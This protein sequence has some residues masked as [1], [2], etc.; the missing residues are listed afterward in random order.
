MKL[1]ITCTAIV[2]L[3]L[4]VAAPPALAVRALPTYVPVPFDSPQPQAAAQFGTVMA[5]VGDVD[6]DGIADVGVSATGQNVGGLLRAGTVWVFS[7]ATRQVIRTI[8]SPDPQSGGG[9]GDSI[10]GIGDVSGDG[11]A[12]FMI[13]QD[14]LDVFVGVDANGVANAQ[15][16]G[17]VEPN[18]C[19]EG[20]GRLYTFSGATGALIRRIDDPTPQT[21]AFFGA[22]TIAPGDLNGNGSIDIVAG[23]FETV[24]TCT[25]DFDFDPTT[26][27]T[28][29]PCPVGAADAVDSRTGALIHR[30]DDPDPA[31][32]VG[33]ASGI[34]APG[35][36]TGD[37]VGD[38]LIGAPFAGVAGHAHLFNGRT[39][40][41]VRSYQPPAGNDPGSG[42]GF[43]VGGGIEPGD[44]NRDGVPDLLLA[45]PGQGNGDAH[46]AGRLYVINAADGAILRTLNDPNPRP[47]GSLGFLRASAGDINADGT[48]DILAARPTFSPAGYLPDP[49]PG[50]A[51]YVFDGATGAALVTLPGMSDSGPGSS[52][53]SPGDV[54]RDGYPDYFLGGRLL[55]AGAGA[56]SG[57][58]VAELS[59]APPVAPPGTT[60][61]PATTP[62]PVTPADTVKPVVLSLSVAP[63]AFRAARTGASVVTRGGATVT[64]V[65]S[66]KASVRFGVERAVAGRSVGG[67]CVSATPARRRAKPCTRYVAV[68]GSFTG[69]GVSGRNTLRFS[70]RLAG[71][72]LAAGRYRLSA[73][74]TD[75]AANTSALKR[76]APFRIKR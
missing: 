27:D 3:V 69:S 32:N 66:E 31:F 28:T 15:P 52:V 53:A 47:G 58:V 62:P 16:C 13:V 1:R 6:G 17:A 51:A 10:A 50:G 48:P 68:A 9:F 41:L 8:Q 76:S 73:S 37:G 30:F 40:A 55:D 21:F 7:G 25:G 33:F 39:G 5:V 22:F 44:V 54:N 60:T 38:V 4:G 70:G 34:F 45:S 63:R 49:P 43:G 61:P 59:V 11:V 36:V 46:N 72:R 75:P 24:G 65:L 23:T 12:D 67:R 18:G 57:R 14:G 74:A 26:P 42:F 71:R 29:G 64:Y 20:Q 35:D 2:A 19:N 56:A